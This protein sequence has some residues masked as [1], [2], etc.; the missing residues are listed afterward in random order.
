M[1]EAG[2]TRPLDDGGILLGGA[3]YLCHERVLQLG[4]PGFQY[5]RSDWP[6]KVRFAGLVQGRPVT[7]AAAETET[8]AKAKAKADK[9]K[10]KDPGFPW[11]PELVANSA[12][13]RDDPA[14]RKVVVVTQG[15][16]EINPEDLILPTIRAFAPP[17]PPST[18][19]SSS[20]PATATTG[21]SSSA[22]AV[23]VTGT[24]PAPSLTSD[25][26]L[27][28]AILGWKGACLTYTASPPS[29]PPPPPPRPPAP[30]PNKTSST[31]TAAATATTIATAA[32]AED[33]DNDEHSAANRR[34]HH[35]P[36]S[37][38]PSPSP[39]PSNARVADYLSYDA[40]LAHADAWVHNGGYGAVC[41]GLAHG[42]PMVVAGEGMDKGENARRVAWSGVGV[43]LYAPAPAPAPALFAPAYTH[44]HTP[45]RSAAQRRPSPVQVR[46]AVEL[47]V[48]GA[49]DE[50]VLLG[51][52]AGGEEGGGGGGGG[53]G[54]AARVR[55]LRREADGLD[56]F[57]I[58]HE[59]LCRLVDGEG[60]GGGGGGGGTGAGLEE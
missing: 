24:T 57:G 6:A 29:S 41:H 18:S 42:V 43:D 60:S 2:A 14:R 9:D 25:N 39:L 50:E 16:V 44:A 12:L 38:S 23:V 59:E 3:N 22:S 56:C 13:D 52:G 47:V 37:P 55:A 54:F 28:I 49:A 53:G 32:Q 51:D 31:A 26:V 1:R 4:V 20:S 21:S 45:G 30:S 27:V 58:V 5:P 33:D 40:A 48:L 8:Q 36:S 7:S 10:D 46:A 11:W 19:S 34:G 17:S 15:T 35:T